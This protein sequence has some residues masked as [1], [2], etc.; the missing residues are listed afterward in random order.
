MGFVLSF[1]VLCNFLCSDLCSG[2]LI[3]YR[4]LN[5]WTLQMFFRQITPSFLF[6]ISVENIPFFVFVYVSFSVRYFLHF[7]AGLGT[8]I[9]T[10]TW[11]SPIHD[12]FFLRASVLFSISF[13]V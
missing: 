1:F 12:F 4:A 3:P 9:I 2:G 8:L 11:R 13:G 7:L 10:G 5:L 6:S